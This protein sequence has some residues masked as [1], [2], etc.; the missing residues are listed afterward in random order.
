M[1]KARTETLIRLDRL[2][3]MGGDATA[4]C[5]AER[6][7]HTWAEQECGDGNDHASWCIERDEQT[8]IPYRVVYP[9]NGPS[10]RTRTPD[11]EKGALTRVKA[12]AERYGLG[13]YHQTDPRGCALYLLRP[14]DVPEGQDPSAYYSRGVGVCS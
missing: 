10:R 1:S 11:R 8:G 5:R 9:H 14:G 3:I 4:L 6:V 13:F 12:I 7:L 2:G